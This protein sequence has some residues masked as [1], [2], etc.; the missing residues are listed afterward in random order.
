MFYLRTCEISRRL[1]VTRGATQ[2]YQMLGAFQAIAPFG[3]SGSILMA[4]LGF[5]H[6]V[7]RSCRPC[8]EMVVVGCAV[9]SGGNDLNDVSDFC[10]GWFYDNQ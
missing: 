10:F 9:I 8:D 7:P 5:I 2:S 6:A 3:T 1:L 4:N